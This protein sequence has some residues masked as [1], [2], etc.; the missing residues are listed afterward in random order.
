[1]KQKIIVFLILSFHFVFYCCVY[2]QSS[3]I[4][5]GWAKNSVNT[6]VFR[7][8]SVVTYNGIQ[9]VTYYDSTGHVILAKRKTGTDGWVV[10][11]TS[12]TGNIVDAHCSISIMVDNDGYLHMAWNHHNNALHYC[13]SVEPDSL[14]LTA[15]MSMIGTLENDVTYPEFFRLPGGDLIFMY[16]HGVSGRG[17]LV[18][19]KYMLAEKQW[20]RLHDKLIDGQNVRNA[21]WQSYVDTNGT[22]HVSWVWRETWDVS[23]NH[24]LCY[25]R[26]NDGGV[27]WEKSDG[28]EYIIPV[29]VATAEYACNISQNSELI[30]Q[31]SMY[32]DSDGN[33]YIATYWTPSWTNVPQYHMVYHDSAGWKSKQISNRS[34]AFSL[35]G[36]GTKKIPVSRPQILVDD[37]ND[38]V[39]V[40]LIYRDE[41]RNSK[42]S[43]NVCSNLDSDQWL[44]YDLTD[45]PV[46][47]WEP[48][49]DTELWKDSSRL[50]IFVQRSGQ[51][52]AE[53]LEDIPAQPVYIIEM[54]QDVQ[55]SDTINVPE[56]PS[57]F[58]KN[59]FNKVAVYPNPVKICLTIRMQQSDL[60]LSVFNITGQL[61]MKRKL[62]GNG[63]QMLDLDFLDPGIYILQIGNNRYNSNE[64]L[65]KE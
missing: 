13:K 54:Q 56:P 29:T 31:T 51:G 32:A 11:K 63:R 53:G 22:I 12:Y 20:V 39:K 25:A 8:N 61:L 43:V 6:A 19:N 16:R 17:N 35:S 62:N 40:Y 58:K 23:T 24:D 38:S 21:Y 47:S 59:E 4:G 5:L 9:Y 27:T 44:V 3:Y 60:Q 50:N 2:S 7:K 10:N 48:S 34:T 65:V 45:F 37:K 33:P 52:D 30:N 42:V 64:I 14:E 46:D 49:Y 18:I 55:P 15:E 57:V 26:S 28:Q 1:M 36:G 41:E